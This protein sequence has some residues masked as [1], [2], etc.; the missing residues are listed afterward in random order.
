M[1]LDVPSNVRP[2]QTI[3]VTGTGFVP[4]EQVQVIMMSE[5]VVLASAIADGDGVAV[6]TVR[7][8]LA[9]TSGEHHLY[10]YGMTSRAGVGGPT[11]VITEA[12]T[13]VTADA[14]PV[15]LALTGSSTG[16]LL[17]LG[18]VLVALG[19]SFLVRSTRRASR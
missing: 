11:Q 2:G 8:P 14:P 15:A 10:M 3:T 9:A 13:P 17:T 7:I 19:A 18:F 6:A 1:G 5:P 4:G 16:R 12:A